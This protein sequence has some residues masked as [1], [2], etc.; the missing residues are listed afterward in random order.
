MAK[1]TDENPVRLLK[2]HTDAGREYPPGSIIYL[3]PKQRDRLTAMG[4][5]EDVAASTSP[6]EPLPLVA[7]VKLRKPTGKSDKAEG[8]NNVM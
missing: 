4:I 7:E 5:C 6:G 3:R 2:S 1:A 8:D